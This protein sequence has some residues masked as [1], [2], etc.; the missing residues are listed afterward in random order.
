MSVAGSVAL[1]LGCGGVLLWPTVEP[2][3][4]VWVLDRV[5][6]LDPGRLSSRSSMVSAV[7]LR[8]GFAVKHGLS[9]DIRQRWVV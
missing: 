2:A 6:L 1:E 5:S 8:W 9:L 3:F 7:C 4:R